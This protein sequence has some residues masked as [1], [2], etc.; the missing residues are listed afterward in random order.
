MTAGAL[1]VS[2]QNAIVDWVL[3]EIRDGIDNKQIVSTSSAL[4]QRDGDVT[5]IDGSSHLTVEC[6]ASGEYFVSIRHRNHLGVMTSGTFQF[7][8]GPV[9]I[10]FPSPLTPTFGTE[11]QKPIEGFNAL[12]AG[13]VLND[14]VIRYAGFQ[15]D[16]DPILS[17]IGLTYP[18]NTITGYFPEDVNL[19]GVV[20]Y[21]GIHNDRDPILLNIGF[22]VPTEVRVEQLP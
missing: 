7:G 17:R 11:A 16:R 6:L 9:Q 2:G 1:D 20:K 10:D 22:V 18:T 4:L 5:D 14:G 15:N 19:D 13:N 3:V 12:W 21:A 8:N